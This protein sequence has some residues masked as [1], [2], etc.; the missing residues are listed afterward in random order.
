M[1]ATPSNHGTV[2]PSESRSAFPS[3]VTGTTTSL[4]G[5]V[6]N[7]TST[8]PLRRRAISTRPMLF[9]CASLIWRVAD[10]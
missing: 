7:N 10:G 5:M 3:L 8:V 4:H 9:S 2:Y 6:G 1:G